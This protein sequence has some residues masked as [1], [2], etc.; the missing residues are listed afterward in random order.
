MKKLVV[1]VVT[2]LLAMPVMFGKTLK[3]SNTPSGVSKKETKGTRMARIESEAT[4]PSAEAEDSFKAN[5]G[6]APDVKW[7][8]SAALD[9]AT[10]SKN[11]TETQAIFDF[12]GKLIGTSTLQKF[13]DLPKSAQN[14]ITR[15]Y[16]D[17]TIGEVIHLTYLGSLA[18][19]FVLSGNLYNNPSNYFVDLK[20]GARMLV[21]EVT[22]DGETN[23]FSEK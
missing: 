14:R 3:E 10:Y 5:I 20:K 7:S 22:P 23:L 21:I 1:I 18:P 4:T 17:Y 8:H 6:S 13:S 19:D 9:V 12:S 16:K 2:L 11:N 15:Q